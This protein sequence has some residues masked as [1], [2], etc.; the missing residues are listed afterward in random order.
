MSY[1]DTEGV[2]RRADEEIVVQALSALGIEVE[3]VGDAASVV[4]MEDATA[5]PPLSPV[6]VQWTDRPSRAVPVIVPP[7][8]AAENVWVSLEL[9]N[10][11]TRHRRLTE[12][13]RAVGRDSRGL[14]HF[15]LEL[16]SPDGALPTGYHHLRLEGP[17]VVTSSLLV[18][19]PRCPVATRGWGAFLPLFA[20]GSDG[21]WGVGRLADLGALR[22]FVGS[23][24]ASFLGTLP[25][26]PTFLD[27]PSSD[28]S[29]Y[30]PITRL[31][32]NEVYVDPRIEPELAVSEEARRLLASDSF[33]ARIDATRQAPSVDHAGTLAAVRTILEP[34]SRAL[35][36]G[37]SLRREQFE[38]FLG[39]RPHVQ[40]YAEFRARHAATP[41]PDVGRV[42][43]YHLYA[44]W[45]AHEQLAAAAGRGAGTGLYLD[46]PIG[47]H[48]DGFDPVDRPEAFVAGMHGGAPPDAFFAQGQD[49]S[50]PP[51]HPTGIRGGDF[52]YIVS[53]LRQ[54]MS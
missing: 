8:V 54:V 2:E 34:L 33:R 11:G 17:G 29:P 1:T 18:V 30:L 20:L 27:D 4:A 38:T 28:P 49:W 48:P 42:V 52:D 22:S 41:G 35:F 23:L 36:V 32:W 43:E 19:A 21:D 25:L 26:Y 9:E 10:G 14:D 39:E 47:V 12:I 46:V 44:Q 16:S 37:P 7:G 51:L 6:E 31:G 40:R 45:V 3:R 50:F 15:R 13:A 53:Y 24:G 5:P